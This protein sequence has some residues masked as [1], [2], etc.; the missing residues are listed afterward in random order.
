MVGIMLNYGTSL[1]ISI[2]NHNIKQL[3]V[4]HIV[5]KLLH[6]YRIQYK[7]LGYPVLHFNDTFLVVVSLLTTNILSTLKQHIFFTTKV[8]I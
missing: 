7:M 2:E 3:S 8:H 5:T 4:K 1:I 6:F